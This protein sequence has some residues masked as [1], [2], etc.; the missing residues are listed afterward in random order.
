MERERAGVDGRLGQ[1]RLEPGAQT[2][3]GG[4]RETERKKPEKKERQRATETKEDRD[5][6]R[7]REH[8]GGTQ[9][10]QR[11]RDRTERNREG[12][13]WEKGAGREAW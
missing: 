13:R 12:T 6:K 11:H 1:G 7:D 3:R 4:G 8:R 10:E 5:E 2:K 9:R